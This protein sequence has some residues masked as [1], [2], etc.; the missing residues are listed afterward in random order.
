MTDWTAIKQRVVDTSFQRVSEWVIYKSVDTGT[1]KKVRAVPHFL[2]DLA[3][4]AFEAFVSEEQVTFDFLKSDIK[5]WN[6]GD[7]I[8]H[9]G[10]VYTVEHPTVIGTDEMILRLAVNDG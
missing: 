1:P 9:I 2:V 4:G 10:K 5:K 3:P 7:T 6:R 8:R